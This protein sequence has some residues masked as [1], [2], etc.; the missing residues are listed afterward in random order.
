MTLLCLAPTEAFLLA[1][2]ASQ[3]HLGLVY[4]NLLRRAGCET[5]SLHRFFGRDRETLRGGEGKK[6]ERRGGSLSLIKL[7]V[8]GLRAKRKRQK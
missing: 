1:R 4:L 3:P 7:K 5:D 6:G 2:S 8:W